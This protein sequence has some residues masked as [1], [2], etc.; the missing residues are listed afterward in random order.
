M[1]PQP[2]DTTEAPPLPHPTHPTAP[3]WYHSRHTG[4]MSGRESQ[5]FRKV[6]TRARPTVSTK[7]LD[8]HINFTKEFGEEG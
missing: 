5:D 2:V 4:L 1:T 6:L 8:T 7:D 3:S